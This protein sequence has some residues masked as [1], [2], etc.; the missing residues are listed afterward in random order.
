MLIAGVWKASIGD[1]QELDVSLVHHLRYAIGEATC[2][3]R[4]YYA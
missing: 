4:G 2:P 1:M 3:L